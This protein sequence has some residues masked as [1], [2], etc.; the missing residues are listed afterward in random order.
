MNRK[1]AIVNDDVYEGNEQLD[2][3]V[4]SSLSIRSGLVRYRNADSSLCEGTCRKT[5]RPVTITDEEDVPELSLAAVPESI[6]EADDDMT[7]DIEENVSALT[8]AITNSKTFA[9]DQTITLTFAGT[10]PA[11]DYTVALADADGIAEGHQ[12][13]LPAGDD[14]VAVTLTAQDNA[15]R[16]GSLTVE[17]SGSLDGVAFGQATVTITD[18]D[19]DNIA[20]MASDGT[21]TTVED[22]EYVFTAA[23][24]NFAD[25]DTGDVLASVA[26]TSLPAAGKGTLEL[27]G[28]AI[29]SGNLPQT[30]TKDEL[31]ARSLTYTP[32]AGESG[33]GFATFMFQVND[34]TDPSASTYTMTVHVRSMN[35]ATGQPEITGTVAVG[36]TLTAGK[37]DITDPNGLPATFPDDYLFQ[38]VRVDS[39]N[40]ETP[41]AGATSSTYVL[42]AADMG[43]TI[44]VRVSFTD[45]ADNDEGPLESD[46][47]AVVPVPVTIAANH[48]RIGAGIEK[49]VFTLTRQGPTA[50]P[51]EVTVAIVQD[52]SWLNN[53]DLSRTVTFG[54]G[55]E[56]TERRFSPDKLSLTPET[57]GNLT[58]TV[59]GT[60]IAGGE[61]T[62]EIVSLTYPPITIAFDEDAYTFAEDASAADVNIYVVATLDPAYP[63]APTRDFRF[64][65]LTGTDTAVFPQDY[66]SLGGR[67]KIPSAAYVL[68]D[69]RFVAR[70]LL[71]LSPVDD[72]VYEGSERFY[73]SIDRSGGGIPTGLVQFEY[74]DGSICVP[75]SGDERDC[76]GKSD[77]RY[78]VTITDEEDKPELSL[79]AVPVSIS[80]ADDDM[81]E[82]IDENVSAV[83]VSITNGKTF[84]VDQTI[85]LAFGGTAPGTDYAVEPED[86]DPNNTPGHQVTL[87][88]G[89][90][91]VAVT[92][93]ANDNTDVD[94]SRTVEVSGS[95]DD[96]AFGQA[97]VTITDDEGVNIA[98]RVLSIE[99]QAPATSPTSADSLI[100]RVTFDEHVAN[101]DAADFAVSGTAATVTAVD[102][103]TAST[104]YDVTVSGGDLADLNGTVTL[105]F[106]SDQDIEDTAGTA[107]SDTA[108]TGTNEN[109]YAVDN[110]APAVLSIERQDPATSP[111]KA[112]SL[113]WRVTFDEHV[114]NVDAADFAVNGTAAT[115][116]A[117]DEVTASTVYDVTVS[118]GDL[119]DLNGTVTLGFASDQDI[120][121]AAG[122]ALSDTAPT[123]TN[124]ASYAVDNSAPAVTSIARQ[125]P[126][127]SPTKADSLTW[128]VT[129]DEHVANVDAADFAVSGTTATV[130]AVDEVTASTVYDVTV[131]GGDLADLNG[132]VTLGFASGQ[133]IADTSSNALAN[134]TP[135]GT[136]ENTY[137]VDNTAPTVDSASA[138]G[139][140]LV[141]TFSED[142]GQADN[143]VNSAFT[144]EKT[145][146]GGSA[147]SVALAGSP[148][149]D[150]KTVTLTL[151]AAVVHTDEVTVSYT[152]PTTGTDNTRRLR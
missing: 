78:P 74:P 143:L 148:A 10:A 85:T 152:K 51:L 76:E 2:V 40:T 12:V 100:W 95:L 68:V 37:G 20:P 72:D 145:P 107:L 32:P 131:S 50:D 126:A 146:T 122:T 33:D 150:G 41:I 142:L 114:A 121:D 88:A 58:A 18:D 73:V 106:A 7:E 45:G 120:Q 43:S 34:G 52:E 24:F 56:D 61:K 116:T 147:Q 5:S 22:T 54:A 105:G 141:V 13:T 108:P 138:S 44:K 6:S 42:V 67:S 136:D 99:R 149:I 98:P 93:T 55:D 132:T 71:E 97:S 83:T 96:V 124:E 151:G 135:T 89:D 104:V 38:W 25:T 63:R 30:V 81:T 27:D 60:G 125:D 21:V 113:T 94:D 66:S 119:A 87:P 90:D 115:V 16:D 4:E 140:S 65:F 29:S 133:D 53:S 79:A 77:Q 137:E 101:V 92:L 39:T 111:T 28:T 46:A 129:F 19:A 103:V 14:S 15:A 62:V 47:T 84:A 118:G 139:T 23:D 123:G 11:G 144:V 35:A 91:S 9:A 80:E 26:I 59:S 128:R 109:T 3:V 110:T 117:V 112:D 49:L 1:F 102:E 8:V 82:D 127:T 70:K 134:L 57:S 31:D 75:N 130:T 36:E 17:V 69:N 64:T 86:A 48:D